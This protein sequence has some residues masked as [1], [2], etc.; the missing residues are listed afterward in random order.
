MEP[1]GMSLR[2]R[3][4]RSDLNVPVVS[5]IIERERGGEIEVL[6]QTR[7]KPD[8]DPEYSGTL[9]IPAGGI[10]AYESIYDACGARSSRRRAYAS[11]ASILTSGPECTRRGMTTVSLSCRSAASS[12]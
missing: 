6:I 9:E 5:A 1:S 3:L 11:R 7:W 8:S 10:H 12:S 4:E 2:E